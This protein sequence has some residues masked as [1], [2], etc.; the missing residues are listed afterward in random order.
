MYVG[1]TGCQLP[2]KPIRYVMINGLTLQ[3]RSELMC[4][5]KVE[6]TNQAKR[7]K[8][9]VAHLILLRL[10]RSLIRLLLGSCH[11]KLLV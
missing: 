11:C 9:P 4:M 8:K 7:I 5:D 10:A 3:N 6:E 2:F 1:R